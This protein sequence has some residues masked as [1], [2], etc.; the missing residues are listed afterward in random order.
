MRIS[1]VFEKQKKFFLKG[2]TLSESFRKEQLKKLYKG[3]GKR[4]KYI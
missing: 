1:E 2:E 3:I 4:T